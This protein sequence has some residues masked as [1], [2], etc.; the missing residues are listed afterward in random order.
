[1]LEC[2]FFEGDSC[3]GKKSKKGVRVGEMTKATKSKLCWNCEGRVAFDQ[4]NC[5]FCGVY[6]SPTIFGKTTESEVLQPP[7]SIEKENSSKDVPPPFYRPEEEKLSKE[8]C[9]QTAFTKDNLKEVALALVFLLAG[10]LFTLF[11]LL[12]YFFSIE[13][14]LTLR[15]DS[16]LWPLYFFGGALL[17]F[18]GWRGLN[19][20]PD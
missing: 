5:P 17:L 7:Y 12:L 8:G 3:M 11:G 13:G 20:I 6:L 10:T 16:Y 1:M 9:D 14:T 2:F 15:W 4:E 19:K 18:F